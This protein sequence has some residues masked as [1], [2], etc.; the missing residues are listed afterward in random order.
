MKVPFVNLGLQYKSYRREIINAFDSISLKGNYILGKDLIKFERD[1]A[2][3]CGTRF[4]IGLGNGSDAIT[5]SLMALN[6]SR[7]DEVIIPAN[8]F[9]ATAWTVA[10]T[11]AKIVFADVKNDLNID[12]KSVEKLI[13]KNTKAIIPVHLTGKICEIDEIIK[14]AKKNKI[15]VIEDSAQ[16]VGAKFKNKFS[17][18]FGI[19]G[20]FSLHPLKNLHVHGDGGV[21][22]TDNKTIYEY[23]LKLRNHGLKNRDE[24]EFWGYNSRLDNIQAAIAR[25][26][27]KK[28]KSINNNFRKIANKYNNALKD[29]FQ[30]PKDDV[31]RKSIYHRYVI[32]FEK[33]DKLKKYLL[34]KGIET[35]INYPIPLHLQ[36]ASKN[37]KMDRKDLKNTEFLSKRILSLPIYSELTDAQ[38]NYVIKSIKSYFKIY[39]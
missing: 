10:N 25:I 28:L 23:I 9:V 8:S 37:V 3:F 34:S 13:N 12:P 22:T 36:E 39:K 11:G 14:I 7:G 29:Y 26:K 32:Q 27:L 1:F 6:I 30:T 19:T 17:G 5:F 24:C 31:D 18:S 2:N 35:K 4:A 15:H 38:V 20:C 21:L 16:S 33:R